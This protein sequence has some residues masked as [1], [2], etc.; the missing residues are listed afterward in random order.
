LE[1]NTGNIFTYNE[2]SEILSKTTEYEIPL[3]L[4]F[5]HGDMVFRLDLAKV[6]IGNQKKL[7][8]SRTLS[9]ALAQMPRSIKGKHFRASLEDQEL[10]LVVPHI[11]NKRKAQ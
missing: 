8:S 6:T 11:P 4:T 1:Y 7:Q 2:S 5:E 3:R 9:K 10:R